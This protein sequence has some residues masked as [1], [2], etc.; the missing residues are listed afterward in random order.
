MA[1]AFTWDRMMEEFRAL[2]GVADNMHVKQGSFGRGLFPVDPAKPVTLF[3]PKNLLYS[4]QD[5]EFSNGALQV[6]KSASG[7][8]AKEK[9]F[10]DA[11]QEAFSWG[12][13]GQKDSAAFV[14]SMDALPA[15][16][17]DKLTK[18]FGMASVFR[19]SPEE[20][21]QR[22]FLRSRMIH[23]QGKPVVMPVVE[24]VNH[25][26]EGVGFEY[27]DGISVKGTFKDEIL[28]R[29]NL[30]DPLGVITVWGFASEEPVAFS[31]EMRVPLANKRR[32]AIRR[33]FGQVEKL[34]NTRAP[35]IKATGDVIEVSH[36]MLGHKKFPRLAKG[37]FYRLMKG[38][39]IEREAAEELFDRIAH[40]N[41][42]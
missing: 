17:R 5:L 12:A 24:L 34:G 22:R 9:E 6:K 41:R 27:K 11:Y 40:F 14:A 39:G 35:T 26:T 18:Q 20:R 42:L 28:V 38:Q 21:A 29:Y 23:S 33:N 25:G 19:G 15:E 37:V 3:A 8:G 30:T 36:L 4:V 32:I 31:L 7:I 10:F 16:F 1:K 2:G 13:G